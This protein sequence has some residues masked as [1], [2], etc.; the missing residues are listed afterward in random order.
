MH[1]TIRLIAVGARLVL[2][3]APEMVATEAGLVVPVSDCIIEVRS[4]P[5][6]HKM[7]AGVKKTHSNQRK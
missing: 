7:F 1:A 5:L 2:E 6:V 4:K 3:A